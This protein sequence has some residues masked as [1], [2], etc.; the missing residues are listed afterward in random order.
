MH[1]GTAA[2]IEYLETLTVTQ[3]R[4]AGEPFTV[5]PWQRRFLRMAFGTPG[6]ASMSLA[7]A[8][9]KKHLRGC[10]RGGLHRRAS[11]AEKRGGRDRRQFL[12]AGP[13]HL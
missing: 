4:L 13:D 3:G 12:S 1:I 7:R 5:L 9:G 2:L 10:H 8:N 11:T 6:D